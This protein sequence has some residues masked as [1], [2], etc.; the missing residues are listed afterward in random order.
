MSALPDISGYEPSPEWLRRLRA[1]PVEA[2]NAVSV[3]WEVAVEILHQMEE[4]RKPNIPAG[5]LG[6]TRLI[7]G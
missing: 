7:V 6:L 5:F 3:C 1:N 2:A 4:D